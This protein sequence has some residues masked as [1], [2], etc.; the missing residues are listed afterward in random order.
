MTRSYIA[1]AWSCDRPLPNMSVKFANRWRTIAALLNLAPA[2]RETKKVLDDAT[3]QR[4]K[5]LCDMIAKEQDQTRFSMLISELNSL[6][7]GFD[8]TGK[9]L[10]L[11]GVRSSEETPS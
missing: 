5:E 7:D 1:Y 11:S 10:P 9:P 2:R 3:K 8:P 4:V 6:F